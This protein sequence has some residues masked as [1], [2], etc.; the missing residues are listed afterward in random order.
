MKIEIEVAD[1]LKA[2][3]QEPDDNS[4]WKIGQNYGIRTVT[5]IYTGRLVK[6]TGK[7]LVIIDAAWIADTGRFHEFC[8]KGELSDSA[9]VEPFK[10]NSEII[11]GRGA[12]LDA[13]K[14]EQSL[15]SSQK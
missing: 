5:H 6:V 9:E 7:E 14:F 13:F 15:P 12:I 10:A 11:I 2:V 1:L 8:A 4:H 3:A